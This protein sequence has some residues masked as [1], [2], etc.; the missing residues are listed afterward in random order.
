M[1]EQSLRLGK[2]Q[3]DHL[4]RAAARADMFRVR[5]LHHAVKKGV[6]FARALAAVPASGAHMRV[7][8]ANRA[9]PPLDFHP[10]QVQLCPRPRTL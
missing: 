9:Q 7:A 3:P 10:S 8:V 6:A 4:P 5:L 1:E 2:G